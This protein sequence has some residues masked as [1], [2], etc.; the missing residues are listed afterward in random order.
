MEIKIEE[1]VRCECCG[2]MFKKTQFNIR[3]IVKLSRIDYI[4]DGCMQEEET[5]D[6][7]NNSISNGDFTI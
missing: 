2:V 7:A 6:I 3:F 1:K 4:C 5:L